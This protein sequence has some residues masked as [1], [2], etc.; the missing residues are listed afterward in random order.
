MHPVSGGCHCGNIVVE[1]QLAEEPARYRPRACDCDFCR[2]HAAAYI[3]DARG[4]LQIRIIDPD[5]TG[6]YRQGAEL[7]EMLLCA[8]CGVLV[9]AL[10]RSA[11]RIHAT[12]NVRIIDG[13][14]GFAADQAVSPKTLSGEDKVARWKRLWFSDVIVV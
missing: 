13:N 10:F 6:T 5:K 8:H 3:S 9:G 4:S 7:A 12:V 14:A 11:E 2:K 1:L